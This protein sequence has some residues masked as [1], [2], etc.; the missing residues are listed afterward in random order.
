MEATQIRRA[1]IALLQEVAHYHLVNGHKGMTIGDV[2]DRLETYYPIPN[3]MN[4]TYITL[5]TT[6]F[7][8]F[9][10]EGYDP[11]T[12]GVVSIQIGDKIE[13]LATR[14]SVDIKTK[15][16]DGDLIKIYDY[17][18]LIDDVHKALGTRRELDLGSYDL[19]QIVR[20][21]DKEK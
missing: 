10:G 5:H 6:D 18:R 4:L 11:E 13:I 21:I 9:M 17:A 8:G 2:Q 14:D 7:V 3:E 1:A 19:A 12:I 16:K 20:D 15:L